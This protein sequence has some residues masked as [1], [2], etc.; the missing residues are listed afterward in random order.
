ML[1]RLDGIARSFG[2]RTL[3]REVALTI[4]RDDRIGLV[5]PNGAGKTTLLQIASGL[6]TP[7]LGH[8]EI[9]RD[10]CVEMLRQEIDPNRTCSVRSEVASVFSALD[11]LESEL[12]E[13][14]A[15]WKRD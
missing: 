13:L 9:P 15:R 8:V 4:H 11:A 12:A 3:F 10:V 2:S 6:D 14:E 5:G 7:D 1:L